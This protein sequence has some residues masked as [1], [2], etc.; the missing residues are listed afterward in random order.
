MIQE[1]KVSDLKPYVDNDFFFDDLEGEAWQGFID[2]VKT[3]G[4]MVPIIIT[5][6]NVIVSGHQRV[7]A[8]KA[9]KIKKIN[10]DIRE[11]AN[12]DELLKF[13]IETNLKQRGVGNTNQ[14]KM[15]RCIKALEKIYG[16]QNGG[17]RKSEEN[18]LPLISQVDLAKQLGVTDVTLRN[19]KKLAETMPEVQKL[20]ETGTVT[21]TTAREVIGKLPP[22]QQEILAKKLFE[23][24]DKGA[25]KKQVEE[26]IEKIKK[27]AE[28]AKAEELASMKAEIESLQGELDEKVKEIE[29]L[30]NS[31]SEQEDANGEN[32]EESPE[33]PDPNRKMT[34]REKFEYRRAER[35]KKEKEELDK[36]IK[37]LNDR[38]EKMQEESSGGDSDS[39]DSKELNRIKLQTVTNARTELADFV[40]RYSSIIDTDD[41]KKILKEML[42]SL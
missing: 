13:L 12:D 15:G 8:C 21:P 40:N 32:S 22:L 18:D 31:S 34:V 5:T 23:E 24:Y 42:K 9:L 30:K 26:E 33:N 19:Y 41:I 14:L 37:E 4:I 38:I 11:F 27:E 1:V 35:L 7:R 6:D 39:E 25:T 20:I 2:S 16:I 3:S 17:D 28:E 36:K 29:N 10:A